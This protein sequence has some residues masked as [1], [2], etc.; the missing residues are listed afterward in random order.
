[1]AVSTNRFAG[2]LL[3]LAPALGFFWGFAEGT[4]FFIVPDVLLSLVVLF[5]VRRFFVCSAATLCGSLLGG[6][7][8]FVAAKVNPGLTTAIV[9]AVPF[10]TEKMF[11]AVQAGFA[12]RGVWALLEGPVTGTPYKIYASL[13]PSHVGLGTFLLVSAPVRLARFLIVGGLFALIGKAASRFRKLTGA[14]AV[15]SHLI[16][17][18]VFYI[19]YWNGVN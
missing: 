13:A 10:V 18:C 15:A 12:E 3:M 2:H 1:M 9:K 7:L 19:L 6:L 16:I 14:E 17:W 8:I 4:L 5:S 11:G